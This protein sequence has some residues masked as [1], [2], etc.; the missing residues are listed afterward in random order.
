MAHRGRPH[1]GSDD[2]DRAVKPARRDTNHGEWMSVQSDRVANY[3]K[4]AAELPLPEFVIQNRDRRRAGNL[5]LFRKKRTAQRGVYSQQR[6]IVSGDELYINRRR[7]LR[8]R[9]AD[10][11]WKRVHCE[12]RKHI[13]LSFVI[14][15][16]RVRKRHE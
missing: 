15:V 10:A 12:V 9:K 4:V 7:L 14:D 2:A 6:K 5:V 8:A 13:V 3:S 1:I 11:I 16:V